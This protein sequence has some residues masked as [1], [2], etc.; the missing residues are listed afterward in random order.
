MVFGI[1]QI[2]IISIELSKKEQGY[3][4]VV[5]VEQDLRL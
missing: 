2:I 4:F 5:P 1:Y 3:I